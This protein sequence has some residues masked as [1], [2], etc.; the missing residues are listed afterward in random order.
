[1][2][3]IN[4]F[5][6]VGDHL[7]TLTDRGRKRP[8]Y[9]TFALFFLF[10]LLVG[11]LLPV[12]GFVLSA[13]FRDTLLTCFSILTG[14]LLNLLLLVYDLIKKGMDS[15]PKDSKQSDPDEIAQAKLKNA[16][17]KETFGNISFSVF[18]SLSLALI[19][20]ALTHHYAS[21]NWVLSV[22]IYSLSGHFTLTI[23]MILK[24][25]HRL[26]GDEFADR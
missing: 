6:I 24:R 19:S 3:R 21:L 7:K 10:P 18:L 16:L 25:V 2:N 14:L 13:S 15:I 1:M 8:G 9:A 4:I 26:L 22:V 12:L 23:L 5:R 20:L 11:I 17:L